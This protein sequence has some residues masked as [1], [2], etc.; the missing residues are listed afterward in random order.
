M[1]RLDPIPSLQPHYQPS[2]LLRIGPSQYSASVLSPRGFCHL[3]FSLAIG[4]T[5][6]RSSTQKLRIS[7]TPPIRR[8]PLAQ[9]IRFPASLSQEMETPLVLKTMLW[10]TTRHRRF[11]FVRLS[12]PYLLEVPPRRF[13]PNAHHRRLLTAAAW[14]GL[15]P[16]PESRLR[17][18]FPHL[19][20]S[21]YTVWRLL[22]N[23]LFVC[24]RHTLDA[25]MAP[26]R[27]GK[28]LQAVE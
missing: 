13:D 3:G 5:G 24:L 22:L 1:Q 4:A 23:P 25:P 12:D 18:A 7:F 14:G 27:L 16:A 20:Y 9:V 2:S 28:T 19:P 21:F 11:T 6:S 10:I 8:P 17:G 15:E 26:R